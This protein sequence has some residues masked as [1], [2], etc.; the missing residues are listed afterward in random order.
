MTAA[1]N[2]TAPDI[3]LLT[4]GLGGAIGSTLAAAVA[5]LPE[6]PEM[7]RPSLTTAARYPDLPAPEQFRIAGWDCCERP[8]TDALVRHGVVPEPLWGDFRGAIASVPLQ[9]APDGR[10]PLED[11]VDRLR[12]EMRRLCAASPRS[13]PVL[14]NLL[15]AAV[16]QDLDDC[17]TM[18]ELAARADTAA[19]PDLA[20]TLAA[21]LS[22]IPVVNF[23]PNRVELPVTVQA[24]GASGVPI[25]G[26]DGKT[27]QTYFKVALASALK[28][29]CLRV[30][31][32]YSVNILGNDDGV[33]LDDPA[34]AAGKVANKT[35]LLDELL[36]Y[37]VGERWGRST[38]KVRIDYYPP[39]GDAKEAWDVV[40]LLGMFDLPMSLRIDLQGRDSIL[41]APLVLDPARWV[42]A[43]RAAGHAGP[44]PELGFYFKKPVGPRPPITFEQQLAALD[45][46]ADR[47]REPRP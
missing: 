47:C 8:L 27:G 13:V 9:A 19:M 21:V 36:G 33:A 26:R 30:D 45:R 3:L 18:A 35:E 10:L 2:E 25:A 14:V 40:D 32:W 29:R 6:R 24:A 20:Y 34:R 16:E 5:L 22:G 37:R 1:E 11:Q 43:L 7:I 15:P 44:V 42:T 4:A 23:T 39:R 41:A 38:H 31:G 12:A 28:A 17:A 46:L